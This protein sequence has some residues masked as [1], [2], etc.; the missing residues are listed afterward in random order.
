VLIGV[1]VIL[2]E[3]GGLTGPARTAGVGFVAVWR[4]AISVVARAASLRPPAGRKRLR[5]GSVT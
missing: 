4:E 5:R 2:D 1:L 3:F